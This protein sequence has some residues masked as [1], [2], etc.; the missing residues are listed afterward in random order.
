MTI[1]E[2][3]VMLT[4]GALLGG[5][6]GPPLGYWSLLWQGK[7]S[8]HRARHVTCERHPCGSGDESASAQQ[9]SDVDLGS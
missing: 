5:I 1:A 4:A 3:V 9:F 6:V 8:R 2:F 7:V